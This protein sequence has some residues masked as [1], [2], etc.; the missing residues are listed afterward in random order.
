M[1]T[2]RFDRFLDF[3][4]K[5]WSTLLL[6]GLTLTLPSALC[7][8]PDT[9]A[10]QA[11]VIDSDTG[12]PLTSSDTTLII[13]VYPSA[14]SSTAML[15][16]Q[17]NNMDLSNSQGYVNLELDSTGLPLANDLFVELSVDDNTDS[18]P[19]EILRPRQQ[20][21]SVP[22]ALQAAAIDGAS[23]QEFQDYADEAARQAEENANTYT[24]D[25]IANLEVG[26]S[27]EA[28]DNFHRIIYVNGAAVQEVD[29]NGALYSPFNNLND[30]YTFA[31]T[32]P[33]A[34]DPLERI[35]IFIMP[36]RYNMTSTLVMDSEGIDLVG[37]GAKAAIIEGSADP[38]IRI[39]AADSD[40]TIRNVHLLTTG[41]T[42]QALEVN[43][44]GKLREVEVARQGAVD[45]DLL[46]TLNIPNTASD[47][48]T[49]TVDDFEIHGDVTILSYGDAT[50]FKDGFIVG[51]INSAA[52]VGA[53]FRE[54]LQLENLS[55]VGR[56][57]FYPAGTIGF[58]NMSNV[59]SI[60]TID[61]NTNTVLRSY[62]C[63]FINPIT[64]AP[65][66]LPDPSNGS[67]VTNC[68][69]NFPVSG[70]TGS[71]TV[72]PANISSHI[73]YASK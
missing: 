60:G 28:L 72:S 7:A 71:V 12:V 6:A 22:F 2:M 73:V 38:L 69:A 31:K 47:A 39:S 37:F 51:T 62:N 8:V 9:F 50:I 54:Y 68:V 57:Y 29:A 32:L 26:G 3:P 35:E 14:T 11:Q 20:I 23:V 21:H 44:G 45:G 27:N 41:L 46:M 17:Y 18:E 66:I 5:A 49:F 4:K 19:I 13:R 30:A 67:R 15:T 70:W 34:G 48:L 16:Q 55:S 53:D 58:L 24:D 56:L 1:P 52:T 64:N 61:Y 40:A 63:N 36:G 33:N 59:T 10:F 65:L 25:Q 43:S 42:N